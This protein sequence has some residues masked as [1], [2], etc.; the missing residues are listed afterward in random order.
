MAPPRWAA[1]RSRPGALPQAYPSQTVKII[2][3]YAAGGATDTLARM[4]GQKLQEAWGQTVVIENRAGAGGTI[5]NNLVAKAPADGHTLLIAITA[6]HPAA[7][8]DGQAAV[9]RDQ[10]TLPRSRMHCHQPQHAGGAAELAGQHPQGLRGA[11]QGR[12]PANTTS[13]TTAP[14]PLRTSRPPC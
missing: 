12:R 3:P 14:A 6:H 8:A 13:A 11:G 7:T 2:V 9:R 5:G 4:V 1:R 10:A